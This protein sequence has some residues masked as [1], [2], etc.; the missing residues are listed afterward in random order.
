MFGKK[1][2]TTTAQNR[3]DTLIGAG[4]RI[5]GDIH[6]S[7]GLRIDG[8]VKGNIFA[9]DDAASTLVLSE[10]GKVEGEIKV[11]HVVLNGMVAGPV[12]AA[13]S[14]EL[15][16][17]AKVCGDVEYTLIEIH[18]GAVIEGRLVHLANSKVVE[19]KAA[20]SN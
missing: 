8:E 19:L 15:Q 10:Q 20:A 4:T 18:Q 17:K 12:K 14:L 13:A 16:A 6:F 11:A 5:Q 2:A 3:I 1:A 9:E 7:G